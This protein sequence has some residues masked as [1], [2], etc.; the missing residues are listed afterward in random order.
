MTHQANNPFK[1]ESLSK[2]ANIT[3]ARYNRLAPIYDLMEFLPEQRFAG[4]RK[5][6]WTRVTTGRILEVGV[7]TGKNFPYH[8]PG[9]EVTGID[10]SERMLALAQRR[11]EKSGYA[12]DLRQ[13][14]TQQLDFPNHTFDT[15]VATFVFCSVPDAERGLRELARVVK[16]DGYII[17]LEHVRIDRP[18]IIGKLMDWLDPL[19]VRVM[20]AHINRRTVETVQRAGLV[21]EQ[22]ENLAPQG[23]VKLIIAHPTPANKVGFKE[24]VG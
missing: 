4:W 13:M 16:P 5:R 23:L 24:M 19:V 21:V 3:R 12:L 22:V 20:G 11:A 9:A 1:T 18:A 10:L 17:L 6:L 8:P 14:D 7:G 2:E 15:A